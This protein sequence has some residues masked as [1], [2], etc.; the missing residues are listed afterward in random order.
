MSDRSWFYA[1]QGRQRGPYPEAQLRD[2]IGG[3][4]VAADTLVWSEGMAGWEKAGDIPGLGRLGPA[5]V[6][7]VRRILAGT[8]GQQFALVEREA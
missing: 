6:A 1:S 8:G 2:L 7:A 3:G 4:A 5:G